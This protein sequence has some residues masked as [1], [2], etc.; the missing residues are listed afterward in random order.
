MLEQ[1]AAS[2]ASV[3]ALGLIVGLR[4]AMEADHLAAVTAIVSERKSIL[5]SSLVGGLWGLGHTLS[6][7]AAGIAVL[8]LDFQIGERAGLALEFCVAIMLVGLGANAI[9]KLLAGGTLHTHEHRHGHHTHTHPHVHGH[10]PEPYAHTHH[11]LRLDKKPLLVGMM[12]GLA[13]SGAVMLLVLST[14]SSPVVGLIYIALFGIGSIGGMLVMSALI[15]LPAYFT[16]SRFARAN[17][18]VRMLAGVFS[19]GIGLFMAYEISFIERLFG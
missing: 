2:T 7:L 14:I 8:L 15:S 17:W 16:A 19:I 9:R 10:D 11:G 13:G 12:H 18:A 3:L 1:G 6:L 5:G 4:H